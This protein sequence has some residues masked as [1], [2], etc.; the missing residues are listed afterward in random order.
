ML[1][2]KLKLFFTFTLVAT[3]ADLGLAIDW[4]NWRGPNHDGIS[5]ESG[6][7]KKWPSSGPN[8]LWKASVGTGFAAVSVSNG[9]VFTMGNRSNRDQVIALDEA[10]G[11]ELW[12]HT[13]S[14]QLTAN[15][16]D[17]GPN[18]TPTVDGNY[19]YTLSKTGK[20]YCFKADSGEVV[21]IKDLK[22][23]YNARV[24][25]WGFASSPLIEGNQVIYN[26]GTRGVALHKNSG[27][28]SW[29]T[30][31]G[32]AGYA[33]AVPYDHKGKDALVIFAAD[34]AY[35]VD[36]SNGKQLWKKSFRTSADV[37]AADP[38]L[39][40]DKIFLTSN[41]RDGELIELRDTS[42]RS[43][44][45]NRNMRMHFNAGVIVGDYLYGADGRIERGKT[46]R[47]INM[48]TGE[49]EW[50][51]TNMPCSSI[52]ASDNKL[53]ILT[54]DGTL[55]IAEASPTRFKQLAKSKVISGTCWTVPVLANHSLYVRNSKG[56]LNKL[57]MSKM[58]ITPQPL[59]VKVAGNDL[60]FSWPDKG[61]FILESS[62]FIGGESIWNE[63]G[64]GT[65][66]EGDRLVVR[67]RPN[68]TGQQFFRLRSK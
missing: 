22:R 15:L 13:Y 7:Y 4:P 6:W 31:S 50:T 3:Y 32:T 42:T 29:K 58:V 18:A 14:E 55:Y 5:E 36:L 24:P 62:E 23:L 9:R 68:K 63:V 51:K 46:I 49:T 41:S 45:K 43:K 60:E 56:L 52:T 66:K 10:T 2:Q 38:V 20:A 59:D 37:N 34:S 11:D 44:W 25:K 35:G 33:S 12:R 26:V 28:L 61:N 67:V 16:Y 39:Y 17:G 54:R 57:E 19:V 48:K 53:I 1:H 40:N 47:C 64:S 8:K 65:A 27:R 21:W 30:G